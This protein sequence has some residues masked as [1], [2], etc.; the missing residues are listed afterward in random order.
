MSGCLPVSGA[1]EFPDGIRAEAHMLAVWKTVPNEA[2]A[3]VRSSVSFLAWFSVLFWLPVAVPAFGQ[4]AAPPTQTGKSVPPLP[5]SQG[6]GPEVPGEPLPWGP[7]LE[8]SPHKPSLTSEPDCFLSADIAVLF[9]HLS[10]LLTAPVRLGDNGPIRTVALGNAGLDTA[11]SPTIQFGALRFGPGYGELAFSYRFLASEGSEFRP[12]FDESGG[13]NVRSRLNL[14][15]FNLDYTRNDCSLGW[16]TALSWEAGAR[17]QVAF[18]DTQAQSAISSVQARNSFIGAGPHAAFKLIHTMPGGW[19][20]FGHFDTAM[21]VG[22]NTTQ[23]FALGMQD[24]R[25]GTL[26]GSA[27][28]QA[29]QIAPSLA[30]QA[31]VSWSPAALPHSCLRGGYQFEQWYNIGRVAGSRGDLNAHGLFASWEWSF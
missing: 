2:T 24:P 29:S 8:W 1:E 20:L 27:S 15:T 19:A 3:S 14:Q 12:A 21:L 16:E 7:N 10:S 30:V 22:Y 4:D 28:Q 26:S 23:D 18:F 17:L 25:N 13:A 9:P 5:S 11:V 31:G 6:S